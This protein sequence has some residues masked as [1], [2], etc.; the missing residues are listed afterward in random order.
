[1]A[2]AEILAWSTALKLPWVQDAL[3]RVVMQPEI[4]DADIEELA[5]L[6]K[7][8]HGLTTN[9]A[10]PQALQ[11]DQLPTKVSGTATSLTALTHV[12]DVNA[13]VPNETITFN[14]WCSSS[15][16]N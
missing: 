6:C 5:H 14:K 8:P 7:Q 1:M 12:S 15:S 2:L 16:V 9:D 11:E 13:L 10:T 3:R 4:S